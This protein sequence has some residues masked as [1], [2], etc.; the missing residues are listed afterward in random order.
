MRLTEEEAIDRIIEE[1]NKIVPVTIN[2]TDGGASES[3]DET[4]WIMHFILLGKKEE[5]EFFAEIN[6][7][8]PGITYYYCPNFKSDFIKIDDLREYVE[9]EKR[10]Q[11]DS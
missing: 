4:S 2:D 1:T 11:L 5:I 10:K 3:N 6:N 9:S 8:E 7:G